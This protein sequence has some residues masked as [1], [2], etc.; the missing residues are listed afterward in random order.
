MPPRFEITD[1]RDDVLYGVQRDEL[2]VQYVL[3]VRIEGLPVR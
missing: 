1:N 3:G 2:D